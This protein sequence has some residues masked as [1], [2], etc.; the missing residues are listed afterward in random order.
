MGTVDPRSGL[1]SQSPCEMQNM[2]ST[3]VRAGQ[4]DRVTLICVG[5]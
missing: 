5:P 4:T 3:R 2:S 1:P